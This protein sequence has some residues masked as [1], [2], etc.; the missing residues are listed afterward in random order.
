MAAEA[1]HSLA[2]TGNDLFLFIAQRRSS[3]PADDQ[4]PMGYGREAFFWALIT[5]L[6]VFV[7]GAAFSLPAFRAAAVAALSCY[8]PPAMRAVPRMTSP[9]SSVSG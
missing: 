5:A 8:L 1:A 7:A 2:D 3:R 9:D 4:H 6:G